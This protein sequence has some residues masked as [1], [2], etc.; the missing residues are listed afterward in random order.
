MLKVKKGRL[1]V[2]YSE[3]K[4]IGEQHGRIIRGAGSILPAGF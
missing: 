1:E 3:I 4:A 2:Y